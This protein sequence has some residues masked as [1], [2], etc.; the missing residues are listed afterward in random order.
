MHKK[1][2]SRKGNISPGLIFYSHHS[3][4]TNGK[5]ARSKRQNYER[6]DENMHI[7]ERGR[8]IGEIIEASLSWREGLSTIIKLGWMLSLEQHVFNR[9][10][11]NRTTDG[12][13]VGREKENRW[14]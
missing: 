10:Q 8:H 1:T 2:Y 4:H 9:K 11:D 5:E 13:S 14:Q 6:Q 7:V 12:C 3:S